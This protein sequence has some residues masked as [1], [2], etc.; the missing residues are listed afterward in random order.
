MS[1]RN[2]KIT[3]IAG[4]PN[5]VSRLNG[6]TQFVEENLRA[7]GNVQVN[8]VRAV[9]LPPEDLIYAR[10]DSPDVREA[11]GKVEEADAVVVASPVYKASYTGVLKTYL[12]LLPQKALEGKIVLPLFIGGTISHLLAID[13]ALKPVL[14]AL[15]ARHVLGGVFAV[16]GWVTKSDQGG[17]ELTEELKAR[18]EDSVA[19]LIREIAWR[20]RRTEEPAGEAVK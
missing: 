9:E 18:L 13:Y 19:E 10:F 7:S 20:V 12:D 4:S 11:N 16:D 17:Y 5:K 6:L 2:V 14:A 8:W 1:T 15:G 3:I